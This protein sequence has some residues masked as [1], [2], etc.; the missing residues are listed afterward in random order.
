M[1]KRAHQA[2]ESDVNHARFTRGKTKCTTY[3]TVVEPRRRTRVRG[4]R[5]AA[6]YGYVARSGEW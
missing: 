1:G 3:S 5:R 2:V 4:D 6:E